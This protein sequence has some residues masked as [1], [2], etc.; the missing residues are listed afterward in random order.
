MQL[1]ANICLATEPRTIL[2]D[3]QNSNGNFQKLNLLPVTPSYASVIAN[4]YMIHMIAEAND[5][6]L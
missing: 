4:N 3:K 5:H 6:D 2:L 1:K